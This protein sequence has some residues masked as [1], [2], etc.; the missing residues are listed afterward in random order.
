MNKKAVAWLY[1]QL[2]ELVAQGVISAECA[3]RLKEHYGAVRETAGTKT[4][5]LV[6]GV[7]GVLLLGLGIILLIAHNWEQLSRVQRLG[8]AVGLLIAA[9]ACAGCVLWFKSDSRVWR[10]SAATLLM[11][12]VGAVLAL[13]GQTYHL[14]DDT[15]AFMLTW[16]LLSLPV[17]Y[18]L[19][20]ATAAALYVSGITA[21]SSNQYGLDRQLVWVLFALLLPYYRQVLLNYR[22]ANATV[23]LSWVML[24]CFYLI[25][26]IACM[27]YL[28]QLWPLA[29]SALF[30]ATYLLGVWLN[31]QQLSRRLPFAAAGWAGTLGLAFLL[32]FNDIWRHL[33]ADWHEVQPLYY[34]L[35]AVLVLLTGGNWLLYKQ[36]KQINLGIALLPCSTAIAYVLLRYDAGGLAAA[37][38]LNGYLLGLSIWMIVIGVRRQQLGSVNLGMLMIVALIVARFFDFEISFVARGIVFVLAGLGFL[39]ANLILWRRKARW[40]HEK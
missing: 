22:Q 34:V 4:L 33:A 10:E 27:D 3:A 17:V 31:N 7:L 30:A 40:Q 29:Y 37:A 13:T 15:D 14:I 38:L 8:L 11:L 36:K 1:Q 12:T 20:S 2:P 32:T 23:I 21:W 25:F 5:L 19:D 28:Q 9:Q 35:A 6:F 16:M 39:A 24:G 26:G 18:V